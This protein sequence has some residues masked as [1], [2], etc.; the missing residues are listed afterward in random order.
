M[1]RH[2]GSLVH[3]SLQTSLFAVVWHGIHTHRHSIKSFV[4]QPIDSFDQQQ[5]AIQRQHHCQ[6]ERFNVRRSRVARTACVRSVCPFVP[7][8]DSFN[9]PNDCQNC[10]T[11]FSNLFSSVAM[12]VVLAIIWK[13]F[14]VQ[15]E[16]VGLCQ[17]F[18]P[19]L[20]HVRRQRCLVSGRCQYCCP[21]A[22]AMCPFVAGREAPLF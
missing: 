18:E 1:S 21:T 15:V 9:F 17:A 14:F 13:N 12:C 19:P 22:C 4:V 5:C 3:S 10:P 16:H 11:L 2:F 7:S 20:Q 8:L 6:P